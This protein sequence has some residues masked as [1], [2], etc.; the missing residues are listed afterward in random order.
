M[1]ERIYQID[2]YYSYTVEQKEFWQ[3]EMQF[4]TKDLNRYIAPTG[5]IKN[6]AEEAVGEKDAPLDKAKKLYTLVQKL[7]NTDV[8]SGTTSIYDSSIPTGSVQEVL[9]K[10]SGNSKEIALLYLALARTVGLN[11][12][13]E[14]IASRDQHIFSP[15]FLSTSQLDGL[16][17]GITIGGKEI[18]VDPGTKMAPFQTLYW[19]HA[20][21]AGVAMAS[22]GKVETVITPLQV[23]TDNTIVRV[24]NLAVG[25]HGAVSGTLRVGFVGQQALEWR[26]MALRADG[27]TVLKELEK[28]FAAQVPDG[29]QVQ[30]DHIAGLDDPTKQ[31]VAVLQIS[32]SIADK[33]GNH[34]ALPR[35][36]FDAKETDPFPEEPGRTLPVDM[37]YPTAEKEQI[38]YTLP[39]GYA[40]ENK[41]Q[42]TTLKWEENAAYTLRSKVDNGSITNG[43][44]LARGFTVLDAAQ[45]GKLRDFYQ[46]VVQADRQQIALTGAQAAGN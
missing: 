20:G 7:T 17:I 32:G 38:T 40:L 46:K 27:V 25:A 35:V 43:R 22:N 37:H 9:E 31:L 15:Q 1:G 2:F 19:G 30:I 26:Q 28:T 45:Y 41:P 39:S 11:A 16:V 10:K 29:V 42:D 18:V 12:R 3:K 24:G 36:F 44:T 23:N 5:M 4:W 6:T 8:A 13:P 33:A 34:F 21:A 14:R